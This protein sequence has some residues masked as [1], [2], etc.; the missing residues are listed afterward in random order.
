[1]KLT[2]ELIISVALFIL[3]VVCFLMGLWIQE[4]GKELRQIKKEAIDIGVAQYIPDENGNPKF[5]F[6]FNKEDKQCPVKQEKTK[7][8][9]MKK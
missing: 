7:G 9:V 1:M 8:E 6:N 3:V 4:Q 2:Y 5:I